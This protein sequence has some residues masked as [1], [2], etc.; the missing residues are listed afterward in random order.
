MKHDR[1]NPEIREWLEEAIRYCQVG[2][3]DSAPQEKCSH[4]PAKCSFIWPGWC[5]VGSLSYGCP[6]P[7]FGQQNYWLK[8]EYSLIEKAY[9]IYC[10]EG[11]PKILERRIENAKTL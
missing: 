7:P 1:L 9:L 6:F 4:C 11:D 8:K 5:T 10:I 3:N 2:P